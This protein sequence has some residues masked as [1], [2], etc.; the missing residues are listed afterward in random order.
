MYSKNFQILQTLY[1]ANETER[2]KLFYLVSFFYNINKINANFDFAFV[3]INYYYE[4][5]I[6]VQNETKR[7]SK[8]FLF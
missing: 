8:S 2:K 4:K 1:I 6:F 7:N 3:Y 5:L